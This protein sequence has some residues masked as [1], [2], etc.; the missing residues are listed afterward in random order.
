MHQNLPVV[1]KE[2]SS[3]EAPHY[4]NFTA[5]NFAPVGDKA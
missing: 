4:E 3:V 1:K 5:E 2:L